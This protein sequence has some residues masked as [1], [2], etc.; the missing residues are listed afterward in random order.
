MEVREDVG[1]SYKVSGNCVLY[2]LVQSDSMKR[3]SGTTIEKKWNKT[4]FVIQASGG[5]FYVFEKK[6]K[7]GTY[8]MDTM[9]PWA[10]LLASKGKISVKK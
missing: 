9:K 6:H 10:A 2:A 1:Y 5:F 7:K 4:D 8:Q 3:V